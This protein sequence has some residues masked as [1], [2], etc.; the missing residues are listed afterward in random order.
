MAVREA[1]IDA[2]ANHLV[3]G[4]VDRGAVKPKADLK[5]LVACV[6]ELMSENFETE[7]KIDEE[8]DQMAEAEARRDTRLDVTRLRGL[9][10]QRLAEK[11]NFTL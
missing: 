11:K 9:I 6:V 8:A 5:D 2:L 3:Q 10:R 1:Q 7:A 4:L